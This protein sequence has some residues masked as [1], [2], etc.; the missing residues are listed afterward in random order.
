MQ[1]MSKCPNCGS[2]NAANQKFC[3]NC[4]TK[5]AVEA[6]KQKIKCPDCGFQND[7]GQRFCAGCGSSLSGE[8]QKP[9][10]EAKPEP[11]AKPA[12]ESAA[13]SQKYA[14]LGAASIIFKIIGWVVLVGG[15]LGSIAIA[16]IIAQGAMPDLSN[17]LDRGAGIIGI[18]GIPGAGVAVVTFGGIVGSLLCGLGMLAFSDLCNVVIAIE[19]S[20][21]SQ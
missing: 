12:I 1:Q 13:L 20:T 7:E 8:S 3:V 17:L 18:S 6:Q 4:G 15:I 2:Q 10:I 5:L 16:V 19:E 9:V 21:K 11:E 14:L